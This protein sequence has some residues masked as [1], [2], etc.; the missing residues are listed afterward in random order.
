MIEIIPTVKVSLYDKLNKWN[1][2][3]SAEKKNTV[4]LLISDILFYRVAIYTFKIC[5]TVGINLNSHPKLQ[6]PELLSCRLTN[7]SFK[8]SELVGWMLN[9]YI[10]LF[11]KSILDKFWQKASF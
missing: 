10:T 9:F 7:I 5:S 6:L 4:C 2:E 8:F 3:V 1:F 11:S